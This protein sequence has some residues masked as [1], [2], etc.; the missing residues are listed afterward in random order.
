MKKFPLLFLTIPATLACLS[1]VKKYGYM[2]LIK[3]MK[4]FNTNR[5][6]FYR[7]TEEDGDL[8]ENGYFIDEDG[9]VTLYEV[10]N[11]NDKVDMVNI[12]LPYQKEV[13]NYFFSTFTYVVAEE[14]VQT[15]RYQ[16]SNYIQYSG[17]VEFYEFEGGDEFAEES[18]R[19][20]ASSMSHSVIYAFDSWVHDYLKR[21]LKSMYVFPI[22]ST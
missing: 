20:I 2:D 6:I 3:Q 5:V 16:L 7:Y 17:G 11:Y 21:S 4:S 8:S 18:A 13:P 12:R 19:D 22:I 9:V 10:I 15:G 14:T 1:C